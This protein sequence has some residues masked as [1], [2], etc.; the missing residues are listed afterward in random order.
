MAIKHPYPTATVP[1]P[2]HQYASWSYALSLWWMSPNDYNTLMSIEDVDLAL[3]Y[4]IV[5]KATTSYVIAEDSGLYPDRRHPVTG[6]LN[7]NLQ[8]VEF[9]TYITNSISNNGATNQ[10]HGSFTIVEPYGVTLINALVAASYD[11]NTQ[12]YLNYVDQNYLLQ[13]DFV[14]YDDFGNRVPLNQTSLYRKRFPIRIATMQCDVSTK[15]TEYKCT[16]NPAGH[17]GYQD[18]EAGTTP[19]LFNIVASTVNQFFNGSKGLAA[20]L[21]AYQQSLVGGPNGYGDYYV[22]DI[23]ADL[24]DSKIVNPTESGFV[25]TDPHAK[26]YDPSTQSWVIP[27]GTEIH[28]IISKIMSHSSFLIDQLGLE[29]TKTTPE[30]QAVIINHFKILQLMLQEGQT[31]GGQIVKNVY[32]H[33]RNVY[34]KSYNYRILQVPTW[35]GSHPALPQF[36]DMRPY[37]VKSYDYLYTGQNID[38]LNWELKFDLSYHSQVIGFPNQQAAATPSASTKSEFVGQYVKEVNLTP[39]VLTQLIPS[40]KQV[41]SATPISTKTIVNNKNITTGLGVGNRP[42]SVITA[43][44]IKSIYT[45][46]ASTMI[47]VKLDIVGDPTLIKQD[48]WAY[49]PNPLKS[50]KYYNWDTTSQ[51]QFVQ[52]YGHLRMDAGDF[53]V[54]LTVNTP[55]DLDLDTSN[56]GLMAPN[57]K[58]I[59]ALFNGYFLINEV[60]SVFHEGKF[61]QTLNLARYMNSDY[62]TSSAELESDA[63]TVRAQ[64]ELQAAIAAGA[65]SGVTPIAGASPIENSR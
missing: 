13:I 18:K 44:A 35:A 46:Q 38:I 26:G 22:F 9:T 25:E 49:V 52:E 6:G 23:D 51:S 63:R 11:E 41:K 60:R 54:S 10:V 33:R 36:P 34:A 7:Y 1:N 40:L 42:A 57:L 28:T 16:F 62:I 19:K 5:T 64:N 39:S 27:Q 4:D 61:T 53:V 58:T 45:S 59:P 21:N 3:S 8:D 50:T 43:D 15:G 65:S 55:I 29:G 20:Q 2:M 32:D 24:A 47:N 12:Q 14:G 48:D 17:C 31:G 37:C 30:N 56:Q